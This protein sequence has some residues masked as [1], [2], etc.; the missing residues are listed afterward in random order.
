LVNSWFEEHEG[1]LQHLP[2]TAQSQDLNT[3]ETP[4]SFGDQSEEQIPTS[5]FSK[6]N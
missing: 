3:N 5:N 1:K 6:A 4:V 2:W